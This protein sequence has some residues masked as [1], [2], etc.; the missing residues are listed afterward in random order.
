MKKT[1]MMSIRHRPFLRLNLPL[2]LLH[3]QRLN[4]RL[5]SRPSLQLSQAQLILIH[6]VFVKQK[7]PG[8]NVLNAILMNIPKTIFTTLKRQSIIWRTIRASTQ[9]RLNVILIS[10]M[11]KALDVTG[12]I[13]LVNRARDGGFTQAS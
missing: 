9:F 13:N 12:T 1:K 7:I 10:R 3:N 2:S 5:N 11:S 4:Q 6:I 8:Q